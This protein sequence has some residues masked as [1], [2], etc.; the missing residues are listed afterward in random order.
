MY[1]ICTKSRRP[2][3]AELVDRLRKKIRSGRP[4]PGDFLGTELS[5][6][7][8]SGL[9]R[10][11]IRGATD[12]LIREGLIERRAGKGL[13]VRPR[14]R[15]TRLVHLVAPDLAFEQ[16]V[17]IARGAEQAAGE[18]GF[19]VQ[20]SDAKNRMD[21]DIA[22]IRE[23]P[24]STADG[25]LILS[26][27]HVRFTEAMLELKQRRFPFVVVDEHPRAIEVPSVTADNRSGGMMVGNALIDLGHRHIGFIGNLSA[28]TVSQRM[29]G[30]RDSANDRGLPFDR[31]CVLDLRLQPQED[32]AGRIAD[33]TRQ[34]LSRPDRPSAIFFSDDQVAAEGCRTIRQMGLRIPQDVSIVGFDDSPLCRWLEPALASVRQ[35]SLEMGRAAMD[36]LLDLIAP[37]DSAA[38]PTT[39]QRRTL[40]VTWSPR[41]SIAPAPQPAEAL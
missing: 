25:A 13:F 9:S 7:R 24:D 1:D 21:S 30:L 37:Q 26:W 36:L 19:K 23:L 32:W 10:V 6:C 20:V 4:A 15:A 28:D 31:S 3:Y 33:C 34:L 17:L 8:Q 14:E 16:C 41:D 2:V 29:E 5:L 18:R 12:L 27:H 39:P 22:A 11:S 40:P 35:P 38:S